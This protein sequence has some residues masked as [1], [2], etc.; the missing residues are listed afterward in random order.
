LLPYLR[1]IN[2][3]PY[4]EPHSEQWP[5]V[6]SSPA[7]N[8]GIP[9]GCPQAQTFRTSI[10]TQ[11]DGR[12]NAVSVESFLRK[13]PQ[14]YSEPMRAKG[15]PPKW[16][17]SKLDRDIARRHGLQM[18]GPQLAEDAAD[19]FDAKAQT[20]WQARPND[21]E[22]PLHGRHGVLLGAADTRAQGRLP[23][24]AGA[25]G[26]DYD[27]AKQRCDDVLNPHY[28][29]WLAKGERVEA[30]TERAMRGTFDWMV[31]TYNQDRV[32]ECGVAAEYQAGMV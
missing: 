6:E 12:F 13:V 28:R 7:L 17:R 27:A 29:S 26:T 19:W 30:G 23:G 10:A 31:A 1:I 11:R 3:I 8:P 14:I 24:P 16:H 4:F 9:A 21:R 5:V 22:A 2:A 32:A 18:P 20:P 15:S 25:L